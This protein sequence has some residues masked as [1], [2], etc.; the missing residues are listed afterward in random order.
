MN[1]SKLFFEAEQSDLPRP[2]ENYC[3]HVDG[4]YLVKEYGIK[5]IREWN[6]PMEIHPVWVGDRKCMYAWLLPR[7]YGST[8][9]LDADFQARLAEFKKVARIPGPPKEQPKWLARCDGDIPR[10][11][12]PGKPWADEEHR[13]QSIQDTPFYAKSCA[14]CDL[15]DPFPWEE[16][17]DVGDDSSEDEEDN[18]EDEDVNSDENDEDHD[19]K[20]GEGE[21]QDHKVSVESPVSL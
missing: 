6:M 16:G 11:F 10:T 1:E 20:A 5:L 4:M 14:N 2:K 18:S 15:F 21:D 3:I 7:N 12:I 9:F 8:L 17:G 13:S 19:E